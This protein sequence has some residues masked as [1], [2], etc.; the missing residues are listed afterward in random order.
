MTRTILVRTCFVVFFVSVCGIAAAQNLSNDVQYPTGITYD[1]TYLYLS[2]GYAWRDLDKIDPAT[3]AVVGSIPLGGNP[4]DVVYDGAG[5]FYASDM[6]GFVRKIDTVGAHIADFPLPFRGGAIAFDGTSLYVGDIDHSAV[7]V[8]DQSGNITR[9][10]DPGLRP[11]GMVFDPATGNLRVITLFDSRIF[12]ITTSGQFVR[13]CASPFVPGAY[14]LGGITIVGTTFVIAESTVPNDPAQG[15][16]I[17]SLDR[18]SLVCDPPACA[19]STPHIQNVSATPTVIWPVNRSMVTVTVDYIVVDEC[20]SAV[21]SLSVT[22]NEAVTEG[23]DWQAVDAHHVRLRADRAGNGTG[24][25]YYV[26]ITA[27]DTTNHS[28]TA[29]VVVRVPHDQ[30]H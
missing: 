23:L 12:E 7:V 25:N 13:A 24:R 28:S 21:S 15:T 17:L 8:M 26:T 1:G 4:R 18:N 9:S 22:S 27:T 5:H 14:G 2:N 6:S 11:E 3:G 10:F 16:T 29:T 20:D 19:D 30:G